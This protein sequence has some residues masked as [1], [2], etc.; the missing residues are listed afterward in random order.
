MSNFTQ[1][2]KDYLLLIVRE[3]TAHDRDVVATVLEALSEGPH[4]TSEELLEMSKLV[5]GVQA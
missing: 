5:R 3:F 2:D 4:W 1:A